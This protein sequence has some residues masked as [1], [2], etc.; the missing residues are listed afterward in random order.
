MKTKKVKKKKI[1]WKVLVRFCIFLFF[2]YLSYL[3]ILNLPTKNILIKGNSLVSDYKIINAIEY[4]D[5]P[6]L[7]SKK[8]K[9]LTEIILKLD[10]INKVKIT[11]SLNGILTIEVEESYPL[12]FNRNNNK[13]ILDNKKEITLEEMHGIPILINY[14][15]DSYYN[16]LIEKFKS[17]DKNVRNLISE[18]EYQPWKSNDVMIDETRFFLRMND[19]NSVYV[20]LLHIDKLNNYIEIFASLE[21]KSGTLYLD[22]SSDK[23]SFSEYKWG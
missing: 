16:K 7:F 10:F 9:E 2:V 4:K 11:R 19:G 22:S 14:V 3:Y 8:K 15:P 5:Y 21:G 23:I 20:N 12:F 13:V 1:K 17:V 6:K 18:I